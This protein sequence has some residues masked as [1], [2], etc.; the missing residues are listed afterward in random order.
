MENGKKKFR[1]F[2]AVL[3]SV[4]VILVVESAAPA[5]AIG[6]SQFFWW[7]FLLVM[8]FLPYGLISSELGTTYAGDGGL[9][10]WVKKAFGPRWGGRLA[11]LYWINYPIWMASLAVLFAQVAGTILKLKFNTLTSIIIQLVFV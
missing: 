3:M 6:T 8:F 10:D 4:V 5:A 1:L 2:D 11:W 9:Y 7:I